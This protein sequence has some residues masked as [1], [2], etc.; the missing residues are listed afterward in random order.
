[1]NKESMGIFLENA[2]ASVLK[3]YYEWQTVIE[4][5]YLPKLEG[6]KKHEA[7]TT[8]V[9]ID[10]FGFNCFSEKQKKQIEKKKKTSMY[11]NL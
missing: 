2:V 7:K 1:M 9:E 5:Y 6:F 10:V 4:N 8:G 11:K 3:Y